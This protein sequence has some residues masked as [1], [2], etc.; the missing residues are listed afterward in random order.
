V[1]AIDSQWQILLYLASQKEISYHLLMPLIK[2]L[3]IDPVHFGAEFNNP[4]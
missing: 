1:F 4:I 2:V 3:G